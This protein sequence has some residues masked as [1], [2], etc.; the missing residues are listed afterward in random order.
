MDLLNPAHSPSGGPNIQRLRISVNERNT[1]SSLRCLI[2]N[3][4]S[5]G[6]VVSESAEPI[7]LQTQ[8]CCLG[9]EYDLY[10]CSNLKT[11]NHHRSTLFWRRSLEPR[12]VRMSTTVGRICGLRQ[13]C[14]LRAPFRPL[15]GKRASRKLGGFKLT[16]NALR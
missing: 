2:G 9:C 1:A 5:F 13:T 3:V 15:S 12:G 4:S 6:A 16:R 8:W 11:R 14:A 10:S 7:R